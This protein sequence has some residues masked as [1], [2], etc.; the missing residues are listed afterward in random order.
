MNLDHLLTPYT[1][2][3]SKW[4]EDLNMRL[5]SIKFLEESTGSNLDMSLEASETKAK[6]NF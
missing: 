2:I 6:I 5:E 1:R 4:I 3:N